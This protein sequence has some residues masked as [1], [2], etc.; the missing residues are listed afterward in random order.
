MKVPTLE[1]ITRWSPE[2]RLRVRG[3]AAAM[4]TPMGDETVALIDGSGL[5]M[6]TG[7]G[8]SSDH[9][10]YREMEEVIW[11]AEGKAAAFEAVKAGLPAMA[12]VDRILQQ[13]MGNRYSADQQG[14]LN[15]G[16]IVA[17]VMRL[18]GYEPEGS[19]A[20]PQGCVAKT[21]ALYRPKRPL[22]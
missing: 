1:Q 20:L 5:P 21:A 16:Y 6:R 10:I 14:T 13:R 7:G 17:E 8:M 9:P 2:E 12:K 18:H 4:R 15:A 22:R 11:S 3:R 19:A